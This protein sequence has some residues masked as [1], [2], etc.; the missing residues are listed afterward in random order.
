MPFTR[1]ALVRGIED[2]LKTFDT[3]AIEHDEGTRTFSKDKKQDVFD[4]RQRQENAQEGYSDFILD[5]R[6]NYRS[7]SL[8][9]YDE[10]KELVNTLIRNAFGYTQDDIDRILS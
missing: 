10:H 7:V 2:D 4:N 9:N 1:F 6:G 3:I 5:I 8:G